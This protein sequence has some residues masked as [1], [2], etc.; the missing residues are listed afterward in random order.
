VIAATHFGGQAQMISV[1]ATNV[2]PMPDGWSFEEGA[3]LVV[4]YAK[5]DATPQLGY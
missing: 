5:V 3:A 1:P 2:W 4:N